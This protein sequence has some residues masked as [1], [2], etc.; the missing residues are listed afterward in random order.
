MI[1][2]ITKRSSEQEGLNFVI[3]ITI[4]KLHNESE[5]NEGKL[6]FYNPII[7]AIKTI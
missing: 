3:R 4:C 1:K 5:L 2:D 6:N 7:L